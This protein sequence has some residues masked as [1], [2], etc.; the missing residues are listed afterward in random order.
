[1]FVL[2]VRVSVC[3]HIS[4]IICPIFTRSFVSVTYGHGS[5]VIRRRCDTLCTSGSVGDVI[6]AHDGPH[7]ACRY[8]CSE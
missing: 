5:V 7:E 4:G 8:R 6:F 2:S 3:K 1:M